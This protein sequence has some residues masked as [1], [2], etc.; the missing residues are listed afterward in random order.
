VKSI[1]LTTAA[2][3][4]RPSASNRGFQFI[5]VALPEGAESNPGTRDFLLILL[6]GGTILVVDCGGRINPLGDNN[7]IGSGGSQ[8]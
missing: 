1:D 7:L 8:L 4:G 6:H 3:L 5:R 2:V